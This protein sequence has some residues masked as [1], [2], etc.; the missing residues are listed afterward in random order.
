MLNVECRFKGFGGRGGD[1][2]EE[3]IG[4]IGRERIVEIGIG[5]RGGGLR[6][7]WLITALNCP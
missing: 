4:G 5:I 1:A 2:F 7:N 3:G 6:L